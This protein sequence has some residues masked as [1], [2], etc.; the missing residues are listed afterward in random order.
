VFQPPV[1]P[2]GTAVDDI[3]GG[4]PAARTLADFIELVGPVDQSV[5][6]FDMRLTATG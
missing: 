6:Q 4:T 1:S 5:F 2:D 3:A